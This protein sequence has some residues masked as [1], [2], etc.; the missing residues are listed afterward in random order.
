MC[1]TNLRCTH[2]SIVSMLNLTGDS[3]GIWGVGSG[4]VGERVMRF[5][6][7]CI[8]VG[9]HDHVTITLIPSYSCNFNCMVSGS[10]YNIYPCF[11][12]QP[13]TPPPRHPNTVFDYVCGMITVFV[14][15]YCQYGWELCGALVYPCKVVRGAFVQA[16]MHGMAGVRCKPCNCALW[17]LGSTQL[18]LSARA[19]RCMTLDMHP[20]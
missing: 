1:F 15:Q 17:V 7:V 9:V 16:T 4:A 10:S 12:S 13:L 11:D 14:W 8:R 5:V 20:T 6:C 18:A 3:L 19:A 2:A